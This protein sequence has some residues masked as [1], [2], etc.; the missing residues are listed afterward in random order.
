MP[1]QIEGNGNTQERY[2][3]NQS[4]R[5]PVLWGKVNYLK[6]NLQTFAF[7]VIVGLQPEVMALEG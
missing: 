7:N 1:T 3:A 4:S 5:N 2:L 6:S